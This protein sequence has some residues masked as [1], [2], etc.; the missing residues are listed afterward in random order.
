MSLVVTKSDEFELEVVTV[1]SDN[2]IT[3]F[4]HNFKVVPI[5]YFRAK[6]ANKLILNTYI[7]YIKKFKNF[8]VSEHMKFDY[9]KIEVRDR[10]I[11]TCCVSPERAR[12]AGKKERQACVDGMALMTA[13][14]SR[15]G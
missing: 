9:R 2:L 10:R 13:G 7:Y 14:I 3:T 11:Y 15:G 1:G 4:L 8:N 5:G 6:N 12:W